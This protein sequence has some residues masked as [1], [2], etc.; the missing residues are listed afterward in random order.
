MTEFT[1]QR[2]R[3]LAG[4]AEQKNASCNLYFRIS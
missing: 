2:N 1:L 3:E 4:N